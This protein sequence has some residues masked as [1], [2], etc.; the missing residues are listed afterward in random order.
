MAQVR[1]LAA[2]PEDLA[3]FSAPELKLTPSVATV[4][5]ELMPSSGLLVY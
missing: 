2:L 4:P 5:W 3:W 1:S